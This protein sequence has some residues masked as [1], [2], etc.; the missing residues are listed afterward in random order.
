LIVI[1]TEA[2]KSTGLGHLGRCTA[3]A[4]IMQESGQ[5]VSILLHTD[6][7][8]LGGVSAIPIVTLDW[9]DVLILRSYLQENKVQVAFVD[10]YLADQTIYQVLSDFSEKLVCIDDNNRLFYPK[11]A[12]ILN[13]GFGG[14]YLNYDKS[15]NK[16]FTGAEYVLLRKPFRED[17]L[18]PEIKENIESMLITVGGEDTNNLVPLLISILKEEGFH[19]CKKEVI[20]GPGFKNMEEIK[21]ASDPNTN[22]HQGLSGL[23]I[24]DLMLS[25]DLGITAGGQTTYELAKCGIPMII[26]ETVGN[27]KQNVKGFED[28][29]I[30]S[31]IRYSSGEKIAPKL[32]SF[33]QDYRKVSDRENAQSILKKLMSHSDKV[34]NLLTDI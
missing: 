14:N 18:M 1:F 24:R 10:S 32:Q 13:P 19:N 28:I 5:E 15:R 33:L 8:G 9:K 29:G 12:S 7:I 16:I 30:H 2:L 23:Q 27:Q 4:E 31:V 25:V 6:G 21:K 22:L 11:R 26:I 3:L 20:V 34:N 17:F